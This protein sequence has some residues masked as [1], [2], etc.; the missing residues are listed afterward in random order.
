[1]KK[2][3]E[4][5]KKNVRTVFGQ[6]I[7]GHGT[8]N[9]A[10]FGGYVGYRIP[11]FFRLRPLTIEGSNLSPETK[12]T[13][14]LVHAGETTWVADKKYD[15]PTFSIASV[16]MHIIFVC[17]AYSSH[18]FFARHLDPGFFC[19]KGKGVFCPPSSVHGT[20]C[21]IFD[22]RLHFASDGG[23]R[24]AKNTCPTLFVLVT[25]E[26]RIGKSGFY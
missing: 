16:H 5:G 14:M 19:G 12:D 15:F 21:D 17:S 25:P 24:R 22:I 10:F 20:L 9:S 11:F 23:G 2:I 7:I 8:K 18:L 13:T 26:T 6:D 3:Q 1:M 4:D